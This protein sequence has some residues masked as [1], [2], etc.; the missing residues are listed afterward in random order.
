MAVLS[1]M[2]LWGSVCALLA[3][4]LSFRT[5]RWP[6]VPPPPVVVGTDH[7]QDTLRHNLDQHGFSHLSGIFQRSELESIRQL[8]D[9]YCYTEPR[10]ALPLAYG[11]YSI[12]NWMDLP[13]FQD[14]R[15]LPSDPRLLSMLDV[16]FNGSKFR[17][18]SHNDIGC[19]FVGVW[20]KDVLR[21]EVS[22]FQEC[23]VWSPDEHGEAHEIYKVIMYLQDHDDD[24]ESMKVLPGSHRVP[25]T[26]WETGYL[27]LHPQIGDV[28]I[29]DQRLSH[30]GNSYY[31]P[32]GRGRVFIQVG[33]G[34]AN[35]FT[36]EFERGT[37]ER[38]RMLQ[39]RM[40]S[41][42]KA[43]LAQS[44]LS[45]LARS[46]KMVAIGAGLSLL[47]PRLLNFF[48]DKDVAALAGRDCSVQRTLPAES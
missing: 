2:W 33:F 40:I 28:V 38:Q 44:S 20:H 48:A 8:I 31:R 36:D 24:E 16:A 25:V 26:P 18:A 22:K 45:G 3:A 30:A 23:G 13:E 21:G 17:F 1:S 6:H 4:R 12:P 27:A 14:A 41:L 35:R 46:A 32:Y 11:G 19:D 10:R 29:F 7:W 47:P 42:S 34:R 9:D 39:D 15:W 5:P 43:A 37:I